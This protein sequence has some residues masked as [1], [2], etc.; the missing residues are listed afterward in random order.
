[1]KNKERQRKYAFW[2]KNSPPGEAGDV[3]ADSF[4]PAYDGTEM[5]M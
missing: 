1:M 2:L 4:P 5:V 3:L